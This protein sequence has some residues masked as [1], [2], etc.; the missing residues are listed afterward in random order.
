MKVNRRHS[1][2]QRFMHQALRFG[3][4]GAAALMLGACDQG[5]PPKGPAGTAGTAPQAQPG[6]I[7]RAIGLGKDATRTITE[8]ATASVTGAASQAS[9]A[10][11]DKVRAVADSALIRGTGLAEVTTVK[12][13]EWIDQAKSFIAKDRPDLAAAVMDKLRLVKSALP[14]GLGAEIDRLDA[15]LK[16]PAKQQ[17]TATA[18]TPAGR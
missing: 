12:A 17:P 7:E 1:N 9:A 5:E 15:L 8:Q 11:S 16:G 2:G 14:A 10:A 13:Q 3:L 6:L 18:P 4:V